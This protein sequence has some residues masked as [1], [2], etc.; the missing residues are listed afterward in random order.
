V[1]G[2]GSSAISGFEEKGKQCL[3]IALLVAAVL[4][5]AVPTSAQA[6]RFHSFFGPPLYTPPAQ[7]PGAQLPTVAAPPKKDPAARARHR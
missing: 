2:V 7:L 5:I 6:H 1:P 3:R 4:V